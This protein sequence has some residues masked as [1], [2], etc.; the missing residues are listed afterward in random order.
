MIM[1]CW[2]KWHIRLLKAVPVNNIKHAIK[3]DTF[4]ASKLFRWIT[5]HICLVRKSHSFLRSNKFFF[6]KILKSS[7]FSFEMNA[8]AIAHL[9][10]Q[11]R[12]RTKGELKLNHEFL[13]LREVRGSYKVSKSVLQR[14]IQSLFG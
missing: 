13:L 2:I 8:F 3:N 7:S 4:L 5:F 12:S 11:K 6:I 1:K 14:T 9:C 10:K